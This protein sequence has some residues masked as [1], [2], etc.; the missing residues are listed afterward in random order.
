[1]TKNSLVLNND[2]GAAP[3]PVVGRS[4][5]SMAS[6]A[7]IDSV[8]TL[9]GIAALS[10]VW[11]HLTNGNAAFPPNSGLKTSGSKGWLGVEVFFVLSGF[12]IPFAL[13]RSD[14]CSTSSGD[15]RRKGS[16]VS[17][18]RTSPRRFLCWLSGSRHRKCPVLGA[19]R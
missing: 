13:H 9:R 8:H 7:R 1:M 18:R 14:Y 11:F 16:S 19:N 15:S 10:V 12:I 4:Q 5:S 6:L 3:P 2:M 17:I